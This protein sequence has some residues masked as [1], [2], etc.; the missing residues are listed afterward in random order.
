MT[1]RNLPVAFATL[2][3][4]A[5]AGVAGAVPAQAHAG[6]VDK[7]R[8]QLTVT[9][10]GPIFTDNNGLGY[11]IV[12]TNNGPDTA[13]GVVLR[14]T[15]WDC[16]ADA[17]NRESC[18]PIPDRY[19]PAKPMDFE[20]DLGTIP[21]GTHAEFSVVTSIPDENAGFI[22]TTTEV[23]RSDQYDTRSEPGACDSGWEPQPDCMSDVVD[24]TK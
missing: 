24:L 18:K 22:R 17:Q 16:E 9:H 23:V 5:V 1:L 2:A 11:D 19:D 14:T 20:T 4:A 15:G 6:N 8:I 21:A 10:N 7:G 12:V 13:T 3:F